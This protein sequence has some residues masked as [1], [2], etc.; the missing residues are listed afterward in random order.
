[1]TCFLLC[2]LAVALG[3]ATLAVLAASCTVGQNYVTRETKVAG[4]WK[5]NPAVTNQ[6]L[7]TAETF[8]WRNFDD[9]I[10]NELVETAYRNNPSLQI[11]GVRILET[12][13]RLNQ[14]IGNLF[15]QQQGISG[16][17]GY[18]RLSDGLS[19]KIP[20]VDPDYVSAQVLFGARW[21]ID[22]WGKYRRGIESDRASYL[23]SIAAYDDALVTCRPRPCR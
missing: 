8:W 9:S 7:S 10:L 16:Q 4:Q 22:F 3:I 6:P 21:E 13:A 18:S 2:R 19:A 14:S 17:V 15:P 23:G 20:G 11:A 5:E 12:R 1:M